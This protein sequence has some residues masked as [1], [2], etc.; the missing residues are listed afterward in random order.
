MAEQMN[1]LITVV[2]A[3]QTEQFEYVTDE[4]MELPWHEFIHQS[5]LYKHID[6]NY[7]SHWEILEIDYDIPKKA[8]ELDSD[9]LEIEL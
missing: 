4:S 8:E 5:G 6:K 7:G 9:T 3:G 2:Y 1:F